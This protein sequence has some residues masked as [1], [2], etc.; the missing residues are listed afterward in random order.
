VQLEQ[1]L[2]CLTGLG[3]KVSVKDLLVSSK[4]ELQLG[5]DL[6]WVPLWVFILNLA[7]FGLAVTIPNGMGQ[8]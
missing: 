2:F 6:W 8:G 7:G 4:T 5:L 1:L 3:P